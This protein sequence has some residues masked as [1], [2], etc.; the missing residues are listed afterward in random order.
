MFGSLLRFFRERAGMNQEKLGGHVGYSKSQVAMV[1]RGE[2]APRGKFVEI[3]DEVLGAQGALVAAGGMLRTDRFPAWFEDYAELEAEAVAIYMY[4]THVIPGLLQTE[5]YARAI[6]NCHSPGL[7]DEEIEER[8]AAR[9]DRQHVLCR[10]PAPLAGFVLEEHT[11]TRPLGGRPTLR[12]Q[13]EHLLD[14]GRRRNV[15][16]QIMPHQQEVHAGLNGPM[17][18][19]ETAELDQLAYIE[20]PG[21]GY[22]VN[23]QPNLSNLYGRY[24]ILRAHALSPE[25]SANLIGRVAR[26]L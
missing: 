26:E 6:F 14:V 19:L 24:G 23:Q 13:L 18:L 3:A 9:L 16:I 20:G 10:K 21:G 22:F 2:R 12:D 7:E 15:E 8:V 11:L 17:I 1:E 25:E 5:D 4:A